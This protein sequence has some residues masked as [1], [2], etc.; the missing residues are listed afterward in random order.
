MESHPILSKMKTE[1]LARLAKHAR[2]STH[3]AGDLIVEQGRPGEYLGIIVEGQAHVLSGETEKPPLVVAT[4]QAGD[5]FGEMSLLTGEPTNADVKTTT[6]SRVLL[7]PQQ[8][9]SLE[10][11]DN[12]EALQLLARTLS[13]RL[14]RRAADEQERA[15]VE[16]ARRGARRTRTFRPASAVSVFKILVLNL[17][18]S[19][20]K[21]DFFD[22]SN[23]DLQFRGLVEKIGEGEAA[24]RG[25]RGGESFRRTVT[26][27]NHEAA[28][29]L[30]LADLTTSDGGVVSR[31]D[32][33]TAVGHRVVH[34]G[35]KYSAPVVIDDAVIAEVERCIPLAPLHNPVNLLGV[36]LC[37]KKLPAVP[38]VAV[39]DTAF[40]QTMP[41]HA[42]L[43]ALPYRLYEEKKLR[44]YGFHGTSHKYVSLK[45]AAFLEKPSR[46]LKMITCHLGNGA[47]IAAIDHGRVVDTSMGL[48]PLEG[49][50]MGTRCGDVDP[51]LV[52][53]LAR[54]E[55][56]SIDA[57]D[58]LL[59]KQ[60]GL[61]GISGQ[62]NDMR[63]IVAD[64]EQGDP[65]AL[66]A[67]QMFCYR[68]RKYVGAYVAALGGLDV[69]VFT[70][71]IGENS[72]W[73]RSRVCL[74]LRHMGIALD[75]ALNRN[76]K[77]AK[78][79]AADIAA[80]S[81][82]VRVLV[83]PTDEEGMIAQ[84]TVAALKQSRLTEAVK[85]EEIP[86]PI[87]ISAHHVHLTQ[88]DVE[89]LFGSGHTLTRRNALMQPGQYACE[90]RVDLVGPKGRVEKVRILG[91]VRKQTQVEISRTEEFKLGID[92]PI[93]ASGDLKGSMGLRIEGP[94]GSID[95]EEGVI[96]ALRHVHMSPEDAL[97]L[98][99]RDGDFVRIRI[100]GE[101]AL[102]FGDVLVR[103]KPS[104]KL[105]MHVD[106]DEA[107]AAELSPGAVGYLDSIQSRR[108]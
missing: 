19:S 12:P 6:Q 106:T 76:E 92:A 75:D 97:R 63:E 83:V 36:K 17:G 48:T 41:K 52:I 68:L 4:L 62:S 80:T 42:F 16:Q 90:E 67:V 3:L 20:L 9:L 23:P 50:V 39:F 10:L 78:G 84:E 45:A 105:E 77:P 7:I 95:L 98:A 89:R 53:H 72:A 86:I 27:A 29:E 56:M 93:R 18:S 44:R 5:L 91:P 70:G 35:E 26:V 74:G 96:N 73:I 71:G 103:V 30:V 25:R 79:A 101:R 58:R 104:Y 33:I 94:V 2:I 60:S 15:R 22:S 1:S 59:N 28:L 31:L 14:T 102:I 34:A 66:L 47:S 85:P 64:A 88:K 69:L 108:P 57:V 65:R 49:L 38:Q 55:S 32:E 11:P 21:Y 100:E 43:Y 81:A 54:S 24:H 37:R 51:G 107:N 46:S 61:L 13:D 99:V 87:G 8:T 40:H 82:P